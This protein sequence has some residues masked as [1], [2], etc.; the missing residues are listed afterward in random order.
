MVALFI[1]AASVAILATALTLQVFGFEPCELCYAERVVFYIGAPFAAIIALGADRY[2]AM[3]RAGLFLLALAFLANAV[4]AGYHVGVEQ[5]WWHGPSACTGWLTGPVSVN[6]LIESLKPA[7]KAVSCDVVQL[8][9]IGISLAGWDVVS[10]A[11][12]SALAAVAA[13]W[14]V[15]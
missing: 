2:T 9:I 1:A 14:R 7:T 5:H 3:A 11:A 6:D 13:C 4:L 10:S 15:R 8:R 12:L